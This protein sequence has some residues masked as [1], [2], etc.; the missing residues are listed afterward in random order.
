MQLYCATTLELSTTTRVATRVNL[1]WAT[2]FSKI[3]GSVPLSPNL[4][5]SGSMGP[6]GLVLKDRKL[7]GF[8]HNYQV[9][10]AVAGRHT[11]K[12]WSPADKKDLM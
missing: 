7:V 12:R 2:D 5:F 10:A 8:L 3:K 9:E 6:E 1:T 4:L 11:V